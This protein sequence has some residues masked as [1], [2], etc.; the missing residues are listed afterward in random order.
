MRANETLMMSCDDKETILEDREA[1]IENLGWLLSQTREGIVGCE[2]SD[3]GD[4]VT[5]IPKHGYPYKV[6]IRHDSYLAII[7]DVCGEI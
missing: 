5:V 4:T 3:N 2:M 1:F 6:N 7:Q